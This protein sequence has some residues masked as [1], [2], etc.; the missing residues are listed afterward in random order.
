MTSFFLNIQNLT[1]FQTLIHTGQ[2]A[3]RLLDWWSNNKRILPW[4]NQTD[5]Y[6]IWI[7]EIILQQTRVEQGIP[8]YHRFLELF[9]DVKTLADAEVDQ[10]M[11][12][13]QGLGYYSRARNLHQTA[14]VI[15]EQHQSTFPTDYTELLKLKGIGAYTAAA[16]GSFAYELPY[17]VVDGNV[18]RLISRI[19]GITR[20]VDDKEVIKEIYTFVNEAIKNTIP[21]EFNQAI[22]DFGATVCVPR[23]PKC[24]T[25]PI[26]EY[27]I[28]YQQGLV[29]LIPQKSKKAPK[30]IRYF[31]YYE[32]RDAENKTIIAQRNG[33]DIWKKLYE[34]PMVETEK[35]TIPDSEMLTSFLNQVLSGHKILHPDISKIIRLKQILT[36]RIIY[37]YFYKISLNCILEEIN[38]PYCLVDRQ[39]V[40]NFA[41]PKVITSYLE[42]NSD[43]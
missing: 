2:F 14:K 1:I 36:H 16:I 4:K 30:S 17:P 27:C 8:Y 22:M 18:I 28:A 3:E 13:W 31:H 42:N 25:C 26:S 37:A 6:K 12:A 23:N 24:I 40:S 19:L 32:I 41:F 5:P 20:M 29:N 34:F 11:R 38:K 15:V 7:S 35:E 21:S 10:V 43:T 9:P 39:K 33:N